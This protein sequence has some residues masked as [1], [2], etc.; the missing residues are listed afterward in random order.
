MARASSPRSAILQAF[1]YTN[2]LGIFESDKL[3]CLKITS[4]INKNL[5]CIGRILKK[6]VGARVTIFLSFRHAI[7]LVG[8]SENLL[9][10]DRECKSVLLEKDDC[11][12]Y[13]GNQMM[14][15]E[16]YE[17]PLKPHSIDEKAGFRHQSYHAPSKRH[18]CALYMNIFF[19]SASQQQG[20][21]T[22]TD[23]S[24]LV[25]LTSRPDAKEFKA[26]NQNNPI[27]CSKWTCFKIQEVPHAFCSEHQAF[28]LPDPKHTPDQSANHKFTASRI[29]VG[30][31][32]PNIHINTQWG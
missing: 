1:T 15:A 7:L 4:V 17:I 6:V 2:T 27:K 9:H 32:P 31:W 10:K 14:P 3:V 20:I 16:M 19:S 12:M 18:A 21:Y 5:E 26:L 28:I 29:P 11:K 24:L 13:H 23:T 22:L 25:V 30:V 8:T